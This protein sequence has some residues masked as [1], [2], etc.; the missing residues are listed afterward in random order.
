MYLLFSRAHQH[1]CELEDTAKEKGKG[2]HGQDLAEHVRD[3]KWNIENPRNFVD[4]WHKKL[5]R[6]IVEHVRDGSTMKILLLPGCYFAQDIPIERTFYH[7]IISCYEYYSITL[8]LSGIRVRSY[9][10]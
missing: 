1:L 5:C 10:L 9:L 7:A 6:G 3:I 4:S 2:K 8:M